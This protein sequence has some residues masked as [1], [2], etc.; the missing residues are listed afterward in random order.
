MAGSCV[1]IFRASI[2]KPLPSLCRYIGISGFA[3]GCSMT[4]QQDWYIPLHQDSISLGEAL[5]SVPPV[6]TE[7]LPLMLRLQRDP[8]LSFLGQLV[9]RSGVDQQQ[10][11][12]I[13]IL[14]GRGLLPLDQAF[15]LGFT[16]ASCQK[17]SLPEHRLNAEIARNFTRSET[18]ISENENAVFKEGIKLA[19]MSFCA[20][21]DDF[22]FEPWH[23]STLR[24]LRDAVGLET[25][26]LLAYC[27][28][29]K[30]RYP[31]VHESQRL[32]PNPAQA[33]GI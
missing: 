26:L 16:I 4:S 13:H 14:L 10:Y 30:H 17:G 8:V 3:E 28:V 22:D 11:Y 1:F 27:A 33:A 9:F 2:H 24:E 25:D 21:L 31:H 6:K 32:L 23:A 5:A 29:E 19:Y 20:P 15:A 18:R 7:E 12:C